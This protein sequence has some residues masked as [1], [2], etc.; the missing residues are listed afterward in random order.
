MNT[1]PKMKYIILQINQISA[2]FSF[3]VRLISVPPHYLFQAKK[4]LPQVRNHI[5]HSFSPSGFGIHKLQEPHRMHALSSHNPRAKAHAMLPGHLDHSTSCL[6]V[7]VGLV[8]PDDPFC[9]PRCRWSH[10]LLP[11]S[12]LSPSS[13]SL[14]AARS[15]WRGDRFGLLQTDV[16]SDG[17][18]TLTAAAAAKEG[19]SGRNMLPFRRKSELALAQIIGSSVP[20][21][22]FLG[23]IRRSPRSVLESI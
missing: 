23:R 11:P 21:A 3:D 18:A 7:V 4:N 13:V 8:E 22:R 12:F 10:F 19:A 16:V 5:V 20:R 9:G 15:T 1:L 6:F 2:I 14:P 17:A